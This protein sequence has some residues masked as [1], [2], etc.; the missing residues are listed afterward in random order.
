MFRP[1]FYKN[2]QDKKNSNANTF[3]FTNVPKFPKSRFQH[4]IYTVWYVLSR[5]LLIVIIRFSV[6]ERL[7]RRKNKS[8]C[9]NWLLGYWLFTSL[10]SF[11]KKNFVFFF[12]IC[13]IPTPTTIDKKIIIIM[14]YFWNGGCGNKKWGCLW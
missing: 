13:S 6:L 4:N 3:I 2:R 5:S 8:F 10:H 1:L 7:F 9:K 11:S 12:K 14:S